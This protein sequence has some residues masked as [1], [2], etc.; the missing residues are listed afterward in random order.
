MSRYTLREPSVA[1]HLGVSR[2]L[3]RTRYKVRSTSIYHS[4]SLHLIHRIQSFSISYK[5]IITF[6]FRIVISFA[7]KTRYHDN[8]IT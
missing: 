4:F 1:D 6:A 2:P 5:Q 3:Q 8:L 7:I